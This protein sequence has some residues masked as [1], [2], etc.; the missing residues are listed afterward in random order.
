MMLKIDV[1]AYIKRINC[2]SCF[3][4]AQTSLHKTLITVYISRLFCRVVATVMRCLDH[5]KKEI[6]RECSHEGA[7]EY[8][9]NYIQPIVIKIRPTVS[10][11]CN[12]N[13]GAD[14]MEYFNGSTK[15]QAHRG[16]AV[17]M[18]TVIL[19][20]SHVTFLESWFS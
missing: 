17:S 15:I 6:R 18:A 19:V 7:E 2:L 1:A 4:A 13:G 16:L 3:H 10:H 14:Y 9:R 8:S 12:T 11:R 20:L 5:I